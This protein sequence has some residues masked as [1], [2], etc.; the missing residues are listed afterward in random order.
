MSFY[1]NDP[2]MIQVRFNSTC[3]TCG[4]KLPKNSNAYYW[5]SSKKCYCPKCGEADYRQFQASAQ[6]EDSYNH[7]F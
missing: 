7:N 6:D 5:P 4:C 1:K 3:G 2:R